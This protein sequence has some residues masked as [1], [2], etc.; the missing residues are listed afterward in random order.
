MGVLL[1]LGLAASMA[2]TLIVL[3]A[4]LAVRTP[5]NRVAA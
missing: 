5:R 2:A 1:A 3:P 4:W